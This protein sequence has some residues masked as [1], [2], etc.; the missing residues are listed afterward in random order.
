M[1]NVLVVVAEVLNF[2]VF[3]G[4]FDEDEGYVMG[5]LPRTS[6]LPQFVA[7]LPLGDGTVSLEP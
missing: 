3:R 6:D 5:D 7:P 1:D 4:P 2:I